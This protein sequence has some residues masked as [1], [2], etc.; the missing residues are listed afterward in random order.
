VNHKNIND[1]IS[2]SFAIEA[3]DAKEAGALGYMCRSLVQATLPHKKAKGN[4]F[5]R[6]NGSFTLSLYAPGDVGLPFGSIPRLL[7]AWIAT[8]A[9]RTKERELI[10]GN[11]LSD[12]MR[13]VGYEPRGGKRGDIT[14][15]KNQMERL[16]SCYISC[17]YTDKE[18]SQR[19]NL[20][21]ADEYKLWWEP[22]QPDQVSLFTSSV[23]LSQRF[24]EE[25]TTSPVPID[26]RALK[27]LK[28]S[29]MALD[30]Y[31]WLTYRN[32]YLKRATVIPW[33]ALQTQFGS[34][35]KRTID[36]KIS[37]LEQLKKVH[38]VYPEARVSENENGL[39]LKPSPTH[40]QQ[41]SVR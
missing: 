22:K 26:L 17:S 34:E 12:F 35:Y 41:I 9:V 18:L 32:S 14:R 36:F 28:R 38:L 10:L 25:L 40:I 24:F 11:N 33:E 16:F 37:F 27:S 30:I 13:Q 19:K 31:S 21:I 5:I 1:L 7:I 4:E 20:L 29:P 39:L 3:Q 15:L 2:E 23:T 8:E 6:K